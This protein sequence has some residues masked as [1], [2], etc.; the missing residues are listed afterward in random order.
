MK[1]N[2]FN[3]EKVQRIKEIIDSSKPKGFGRLSPHTLN[4]GFSFVQNALGLQKDVD[5]YDYKVWLPD[6][7]IYLQRAYGEWNEQMKSEW[8]K[9]IL[10][11][12]V[13]IPKVTTNLIW[14]SKGKLLQVIDGQHRLQAIHEFVT[15]QFKVDYNGEQF[16]F[17]DIVKFFVS[18]LGRL[19]FDMYDCDGKMTDEMKIHLYLRTNFGGAAQSIEKK[20]QLENAL[21]KSKKR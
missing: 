19:Q 14:T 11:D 13:S 16:S 12:D 9:S 5:V 4:Y 8:I 20:N 21:K 6:Y 10:D 17:I 1:T 15:G 18:R 3:N 7:G 2:T